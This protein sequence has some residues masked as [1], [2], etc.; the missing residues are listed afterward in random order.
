ML[1]SALYCGSD[2]GSIAANEIA[3]NGATLWLLLL[4]LL[5]R[6]LLACV[7]VLAFVAVVFVVVLVKLIFAR[8]T[9]LCCYCCYAAFAFPQT[10]HSH[11]HNE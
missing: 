1:H 3:T 7:R 8:I 2:N 4:L 6:W 11:M 9:C 10:S 5:P